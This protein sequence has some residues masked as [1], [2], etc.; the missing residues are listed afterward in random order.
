M[1][2]RAIALPLLCTLG[3]GWSQPTLAQITVP[4]VQP[5]SESPLLVNPADS[6]EATYPTDLTL[7]KPGDRIQITV[8]GFPELSGEQTVLADGS[9]QVPMAGDVGVWGLTL[10]QVNDRVTQSL[11]P[12]VRRPQVGVTLIS[13][14][15]ARISV[16]GEVRR[17]GI[18]QVVQPDIRGSE[19]IADNDN[20]ESFQTV[21]YALVLAGGVTPYAD[22]R[23]I[24]IRR[25]EP[26]FVGIGNRGQTR[27]TEIKVNLWQAIQDGNLSSDIRVYDGDEIIVPMATA[28]HTVEQQALLNSTIAPATINVQVAGEV[29]APGSVQIR[30]ADG[31]NA[32]I[33]AAGG[34]T[35]AADIDPVYLLRMTPDGQVIRE[36]YDFAEEDS[37]PLQDG[38]VVVVKR[39]GVRN[40][41]D[42]IG[43]LG[44]PFNLLNL[45][46][47]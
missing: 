20:V 47:D 2:F 38:D 16:T 17:P 6:V 21:S 22:L 45:L 30:A 44:M 24:T 8:V 25:A 35:D 36:E 13:V 27:Q 28:V 1:S 42:F 37:G 10:M 32:A 19:E 43:R 23:N 46:L 33:A 15:P 34:P 3:L 4:E 29:R 9:I 12:Y 11:L 18:H 14:R 41:L 31:I 5:S 39:S 7:L 26:T 40:V